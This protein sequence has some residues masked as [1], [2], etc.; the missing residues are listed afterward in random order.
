MNLNWKDTSVWDWIP[1]CNTTLKFTILHSH[2]LELKGVIQDWIHF[3]SYNF[4][5]V[6]PFNSVDWHNTPLGCGGAIPS[7]AFCLQCE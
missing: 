5:V 2:G 6:A 7:K 3:C 4:Q 1:L